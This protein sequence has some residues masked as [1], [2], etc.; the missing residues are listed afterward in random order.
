MEKTNKLQFAG[1]NKFESLKDEH[2]KNIVA[3]D[4]RVGP[5]MG[6]ILFGGRK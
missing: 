1:L 6:R 5:F 3:G 2:L 4:V